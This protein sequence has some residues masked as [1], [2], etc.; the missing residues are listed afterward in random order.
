MISRSL[1]TTLLIVKQYLET[2]MKD[3]LTYNS[4]KAFASRNKLYHKYGITDRTLERAL[5]E[6]ARIGY[7]DRVYIKSGKVVLYKPSSKY[8]EFLNQ[9]SRLV[10]QQ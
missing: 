4:I 3:Y 7:F 1:Y 5:R 8:F 10:N 6:L 9:Y 2:T